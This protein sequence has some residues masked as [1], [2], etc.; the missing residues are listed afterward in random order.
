MPL[1]RHVLFIGG[2]LNDMEN[3]RL[4]K[5]LLDVTL[6]GS[7][8]SS[9]AVEQDRNTRT[10]SSKKATRGGKDKERSS[11]ATSG[12]ASVTFFESLE[13]EQLMHQA[14]RTPGQVQMLAL[15]S[16]SSLDF[17][18]MTSPGNKDA[19]ATTEK[20]SVRQRRDLVLALVDVGL[21]GAEAGLVAAA[22]RALPVLPSDLAAL[23][24]GLAED[25]SLASNSSKVTF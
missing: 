23:L 24:D 25:L 22:A 12:S 11:A 15:R 4:L 9:A 8:C 19:V 5:L 21:A 18:V 14:L 13:A 16:L 6:F 3:G 1:L 7:S 2:S 17:T 20:E 10:K